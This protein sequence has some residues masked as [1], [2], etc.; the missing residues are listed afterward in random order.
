MLNAVIRETAAA[1]LRVNVD[2]TKYMVRGDLALLP[3]AGPAEVLVVGDAP[4]ERVQDFK[5]LGSFIGSVD[6]DIEERRKA[7]SRAFGRLTPVWKAPLTVKT[8]LRVFKTMVE[9]ILF[10]GCESWPLTMGRERQI[11]SCWF[12]LVR[13]IVNRKWYDMQSNDSLLK[14]FELTSPVS[15]VRT[16]FLRHYGH[17]L[18]TSQ[19]EKSAGVKLSPLSVMVEWTGESGWKCMAS[20]G[21][22]RQPCEQRRGKGNLCTTLRYCLR[23]LKLRNGEAEKLQELAQMRATWAERVAKSA[24]FC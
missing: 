24:S 22:E 9:P 1:G 12:K 8:K 15:S 6:R 4:L 5:Y 23:L 13:R 14:E 16:R 7:A 10:Y 19:R 2:K 17:A 3:A 21:V 18:R 11:S 20:R